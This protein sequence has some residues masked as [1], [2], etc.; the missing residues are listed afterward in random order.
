MKSDFD[1]SFKQIGKEYNEIKREIE[2]TDKERDKKVYKLYG[3]GE[4]E[5]KAV[6]GK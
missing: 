3:L 5:I 1:K 6:E 4:D 2:K